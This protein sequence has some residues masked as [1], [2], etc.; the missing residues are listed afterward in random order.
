MGLEL[1]KGRDGQRVPYW[2]GRY[3]D[4]NGK[5]HV[6]S[7]GVAIDGNEP[8]SLRDKGDA[9]FEISRTKAEAER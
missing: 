4:E 6:V 1:R 3:T 8:S 9:K 7:L 2:Y 5:I